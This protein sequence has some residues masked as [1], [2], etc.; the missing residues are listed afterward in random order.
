MVSATCSMVRPISSRSRKK[1]RST[2]P[3]V[4]WYTGL[5]NSTTASATT[6]AGRIRDSPM[7]SRAKLT[8]TRVMAPA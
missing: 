2:S 5:R 7:P 3:W 6:T 1:R 8:F 4:R